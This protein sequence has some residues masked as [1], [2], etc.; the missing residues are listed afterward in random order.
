MKLY[1]GKGIES[2][3]IREDKLNQHGVISG[4]TGSGKT[5]TVKV[6]CEEL[7]QIG[8][9]TF[10]SDV[11]GDL[12]NLSK[13]GTFNENINKRIQRLGFKHFEFR[14][15]PINIWDIYKEKGLPLRVTVSEFGPVLLSE[16]L[17]LNETQ[18]GIINVLFRVADEEGLLLM[19]FKDLTKMLEFLRRNS[20]EISIEY[21]NISQA[22][23]SAIQRK[24]LVLEEEGA[25]E[26]FGEP[27]VDIKDFLQV[28]ELGNGFINILNSSKLINHKR[29][30]SAF[31]IYLFSELFEVLPE[32]GNPEKPVMVFFFDEAHLIFNNISNIL[33]EK[34]TTVVKLIRSKGV[35]IFF[36]TQN[37][38]DIPDEISSQLGT[39]IIH[40]LR[41]F[42]PKEVKFV[43]EIS[44]SLRQRKGLDTY[45]EILNLSVGEAIIQTLDEKNT[46]TEVE[47]VIIRPP[48]SSFDTL[49]DEDID[50]IVSNSDNYLK[51]RDT[52]D[53]LSAYEVLSERFRVEDEKKEELILEKA[54]IKQ[55]EL[56]LKE[57]KRI[58]RE[59][60]KLKKREERE[61]REKYKYVDRTINSIWGA[62]TRTV[63]R[64]LARG[65]LGSFKRKR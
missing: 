65:I 44:Q 32:V 59:Q 53:N 42:S 1:L 31:L 34:I 36:I 27:S 30:Y 55:E 48:F 14:N 41:A 61:R 2:F 35:G 37:P 10:I 50:Y 26:F 56:K 25:N 6:L 4:A 28:D 58:E 17:Q 24:L 38:K 60:E 12:V 52:L 45:N 54:R 16:I 33:L 9:P 23:I 13:V 22:S 39:K 57:E 21:G 8:V 43:K 11:K 3:G 47:K 7:S 15:Y 19:D 46:P 20:K 5:V 49:N 51:Y 29:L 62:F 64:E 18:R 63:G 40:Q